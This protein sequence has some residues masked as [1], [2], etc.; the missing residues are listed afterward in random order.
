MPTEKLLTSI[1]NPAGM[2]PSA[3]RSKVRI[4]QPAKGPDGH[5]ADEHRDVAAQNHAHH[6][7]GSD[8]AAAVAGHM[9][10]RRDGDQHRQQVAQHR[11]DELPQIRIGPPARG[12]EQRR[13][14]P[15][16]DEGADVGHHHAAQRFAEA[17]NPFFHFRSVL[18]SAPPARRTY[19]TTNKDAKHL[20]RSLRQTYARHKR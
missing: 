15:P 16:C 7:H 20:K 9:A 5:R 1:S 13:D 12:N 19:E 18:A 8:H 4:T 10:P 6:R 17:L 11:F 2:R 3:Q 14:E